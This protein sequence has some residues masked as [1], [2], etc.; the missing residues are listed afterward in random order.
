MLR[1]FRVLPIVVWFLIA[2][3]L[4]DPASTSAR[5][6]SPDPEQVSPRPEAALSLPSRVFV[7]VVNKAVFSANPGTGSGTGNSAVQA[8]ALGAY[9]HNFPYFGDVPAFFNL[10]GRNLAVLMWYRPWG[11]AQF[12]GF[13]PED[14]EYAY[15]LGAVPMVTWE[16]WNWDDPRGPNQPEY[17]LRNIV[18]GNFDD[19]IRS[20]A[21]GAKAFG[22]PFYLR[23]AHE[24][25]GYWYPWG[26]GVNGNRPQEYVAAWRRIHAIFAAEGAANVR[27][28]W[29]PNIDDQA[30]PIEA[31]Y[32]G[33]AYVDVVGMDGYNGG[34]ALPDWG[35]W[36]SAAEIFGRTYTRLAALT[37]KPIIIAETASAEAGGDKAAWIRETF[38]AIP[39][40]FPRVRA[41]IWF[42]ASKETDWRVNSSPTSLAA[43][44]EAAASPVYQGRLP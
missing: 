19:Y 34:T 36:R 40:L 32:P 43:F 37:D 42:N 10:I 16:P 7:P 1:A 35:G 39:E 22:R 11:P 26:A 28:V 15:S 13:H 33:D 25:N 30:V 44:R 29:T 2:G 27:W 23:F 20:W 38:A 24:M 41:V 5:Q 8:V 12:S 9:V 21:R 3:I 4:P 14:L 31:F 6:A 17:A 18:A